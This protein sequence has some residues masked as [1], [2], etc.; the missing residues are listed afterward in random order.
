MKTKLFPNVPN[1][2][3]ATLAGCHACEGKALGNQR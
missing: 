3:A 2:L 1:H